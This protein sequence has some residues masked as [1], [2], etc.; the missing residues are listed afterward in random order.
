MLMAPRPACVLSAKPGKVG[1]NEA[2]EMPMAT[3]EA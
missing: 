2:I 1:P 3:N